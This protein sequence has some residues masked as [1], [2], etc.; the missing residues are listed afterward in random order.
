MQNT[1][2]FKEGSTFMQNEEVGDIDPADLD[3]VNNVTKGTSEAS[4]IEL[5]IHKK[6]GRFNGWIGYEYSVSTSQFDEINLGRK[7]Y[8]RYDYRHNLNIVGIIN[9]NKKLQFSLIWTYRSGS[10]ITIANSSYASYTGQPLQGSFV[11]DPVLYYSGINN[12][13][14]PAYHRLDIGMTYTKSYKKIDTKLN[15]GIY[16]VYNRKNVYFYFVSQNSYGDTYAQKVS[17]IPIIPNISYE[18]TF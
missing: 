10:P 9:L 5:M 4:G 2:T 12:Y 1:L 15:I 8:N 7:F 11:R 3:W 16:N 14:T 13:R 17:L 6:K 18:I